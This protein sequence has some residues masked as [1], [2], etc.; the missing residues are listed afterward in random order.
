[1]RKKNSKEKKA[2]I[3]KGKRTR[4]RRRKIGGRN[5]RWKRKIKAMSRKHGILDMSIRASLLY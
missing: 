1:V 4:R 2:K 5:K 3:R